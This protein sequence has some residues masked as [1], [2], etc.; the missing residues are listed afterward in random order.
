MFQGVES[1]DRTAIKN[2]A[3]AACRSNIECTS[4]T[5]FYLSVI[6]SLFPNPKVIDRPNSF[7]G[8]KTEALLDAIKSSGQ[9]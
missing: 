5:Y 4:S 2:T 3:V 8:L 1:G 6:S 9:N 7:D